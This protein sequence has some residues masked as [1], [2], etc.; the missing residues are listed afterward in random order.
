MK[1]IVMLFCMLIGIMLVLP[2]NAAAACTHSFTGATQYSDAA[3][4]HAYF[5]Y[6]SKCGQKVY[7]GGN[8]VKPHGTGAT[9][10]GTCS[11]CGTHSYSGQSCA[12]SG[13][14]V[15]GATTAALGHNFSGAAQYS[16]ATHPHAYFKHCARCGQKVY[17]GGNQVKPHG[18]GATGSGTCSSCGSHTYGSVITN[19]AHPHSQYKQCTGCGITTRTGTYGT[20]THSQCASCGSHNYNIPDYDA[21]LIHPHPGRTKCVCGA[22]QVNTPSNIVTACSTCTVG[23]KTT[24]GNID[25]TMFLSYIDEGLLTIPVQVHIEYREQYK[26]DGT[27]FIS[28]YRQHTVY[29]DSY[30]SYHPE[31]WLGADPNIKYRDSSNN[32]IHTGSTGT[33]PFSLNSLPYYS[34]AQTT[35]MFAGSG[36]PEVWQYDAYYSY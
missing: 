15:C 6:C 22:V 12:A 26:K 36:M 25:D 3:H 29:H 10:S 2:I 33:T 7:T 28:F 18:T 35:G 9:G 4:P 32:N 34:R 17:T 1:T 8:Q 27:T 14:C 31:L 13:K 23:S 30:P 21:F 20:K 24:G 16:D 11:T 19:T 5:K